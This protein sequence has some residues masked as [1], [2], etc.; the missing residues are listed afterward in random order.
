MIIDKDMDAL[1]H[2]RGQ[3][4]PEQK[5]FSLVDTKICGLV[6]MAVSTIIFAMLPLIFVSKLRNNNDPTSQS[7][8][9]SYC[10]PFSKF[11]RPSL[12][13]VMLNLRQLCCVE[14]NLVLTVSN[15]IRQKP[16]QV[17]NHDFISILLLWWS[18]YRC[19]LS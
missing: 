3:N 7:R 1:Y 19:L 18:L 10:S 14:R 6:G 13:L 15:N 8:L 4:A 9:L 2:N 16:T 11:K 12:L 5:E 17:A